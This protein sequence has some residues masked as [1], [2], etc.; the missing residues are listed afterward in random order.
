MYKIGC[1]MRTRPV[2]TLLKTF[3]MTER[4]F[5]KKFRYFGLRSLTLL[6][7]LNSYLNKWLTLAKVERSYEAVCDFIARDQYLESCN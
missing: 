2:M 6:N 4:G 7:R 5:R 1:Q 3:D